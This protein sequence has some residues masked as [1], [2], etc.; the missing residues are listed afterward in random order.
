MTSISAMEI[1]DK[2]KLPQYLTVALLLVQRK[3]EYAIFKL[4]H[5]LSHSKPEFDIILLY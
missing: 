3:F 1:E 5:N 2:E 4:S